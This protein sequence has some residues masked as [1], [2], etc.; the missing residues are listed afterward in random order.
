M[1]LNSQFISKNL[2]NFLIVNAI[3]YVKSIISQFTSC[4]KSIG[5]FLIHSL[6]QELLFCIC[7]AYHIE[8]HATSGFDI[9]ILQKIIAHH[10]DNIRFHII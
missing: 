9:H 10:L 4:K 1:S 5:L 6:I 2:V 7:N 8:K 3:K